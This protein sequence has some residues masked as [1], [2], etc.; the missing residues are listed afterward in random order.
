MAEIGLNT[1]ED[2]E[3]APQTQAVE[4]PPE[5]QAVDETPKNE[6][7]AQ[8]LVRDPYRK[9]EG[10]EIRR[11]F[12]YRPDILGYTQEPL[13]DIT[14]RDSEE[15]PII[16][17]D[18]LTKTQEDYLRKAKRFFTLD[19]KELAFPPDA[20]IEQ[21]YRIL[22]R[23]EG[24]YLPKM[25]EDGYE[26]LDE[27]QN[28]IYFPLTTTREYN[29]YTTKYQPENLLESA[30]EVVRQGVSTVLGPTGRGDLRSLDEKLIKLGVTNQIAR[31][32]ALRGV[33][34]GQWEEEAVLKG[35][36]DLKI[37]A[38]SIPNYA[39]KGANFFTTE[40]IGNAMMYMNLEN[41][42]NVAENKKWFSSIDEALDLAGMLGVDDTIEKMSGDIYNPEVIEEILQPRG[43]KQSM[44]YYAAPEVAM[45]T[46]WGAYKTIQAA[47]RLPGLKK[48]L[49]ETY[50]TDTIVDAVKKAKE[51]GVEPAS[52]VRGY[53]E[54]FKEKKVRDKLGKELDLAFGMLVRRPGET[55][56]EFLESEY[57]R[58]SDQITG[59]LEKLRLARKAN[60][61]GAVKTLQKNLVDL[62]RQKMQFMH[63]N[64]VPKYIKDLAVEAGATV[65]AT[66]AVTQLAMEFTDLSSGGLMAAEVGGA[67]SASGYLPKPLLALVP[68]VKRFNTKDLGYEAYRGLGGVMDTLLAVYNAKKSEGF[69]NFNF[70]IDQFAEDFKEIKLDFKARKVLKLLAQQPSQFQTELIK[71]LQQH[72]SLKT[73]LIELS[74][75]TGIE[76]DPDLM[77]SNLSIMS[78]MAE[79]IDISRQLDEKI[80]ATDL[81]SI[82]GPIVEKREVIAGQQ[83]L[84]TEL[85]VQTQALLD[86]KLSANLDDSDPIAILAD[87]M[88]G[89]V[90]KQQQRIRG[91]RDLIREVQ[92]KF[93][94]GLV[95]SERVNFLATPESMDETYELLEDVYLDEL[96]AITDGLSDD[97]RGVVLN[98]AEG[99]RTRLDDIKELKQENLEMLT[100]LSRNLSPTEAV[101]G[102]AGG[103]FANV[104]AYR[105]SLIDSDIASAY[106]TFDTKH[107]DVHANVSG[108]FDFFLGFGDDVGVADTEKMLEG[109]Q[110][111][112]GYKATPQTQKGFMTLF[113]GAAKRGIEA[114]NKRTGGKFAEGIELMGL[115]DAPPI[116]QWMEIRKALKDPQF[117]KD[118]GMDAKVAANFADNMPMLVSTKEWRA[119]NKHL[120]RM[121]RRTDRDQQQKY[122]SM[123]DDWQRVGKSTLDDGTPNTGAFMTNWMSG[124]PA[125]V[126]DEVYAE[127]RAIQEMYRQEVINRYTVDNLIRKW[128]GSITRKT[129]DAAPAPA[130]DIDTKQVIEPEEEVLQEFLQTFDQTDFQNKPH[131]WLN[132]L[133]A[134]TEKAIKARGLG[135]LGGD[136]L[137]G[138][139]YET[140]MAPLGKVAG[141]WDQKSG[142]YL[143]LGASAKEGEEIIPEVTKM[144]KV[145][146][147]RHLQ[148]ILLGTVKSTLPVDAKGRLIFD[149]KLP[150]EY[151]KELFETYFNIP[152]YQRNANGEIVPM[153]DE[154]GIP[155]KLL[156]EEEVYTSIDL[157]ALERNRLDLVDTFE[158]ANKSVESLEDDIIKQ[159]EETDEFGRAKGVNAIVEEEIKVVNE[160]QQQFLDMRPDDT[161]SY[162]TEDAF[163]ERIYDL[164]IN[165]DGA[166]DYDR[167]MAIMSERHDPKMVEH[168]M[169]KSLNDY[170]NKKTQVYVG[171]KQLLRADGTTTKIPQY[172]SS[173]SEILKMIGAPGSKQR[174]RLET[175]LGEDNVDSWELVAEVIQKI[176]PPPSGAGIDAHVSSMSL[177]SVLSRI[178][179]INRGVVSVQW[180]ATESII[181]ASRNHSGAMLR[182]MLKDKEVAKQILK[183]IETNKVPAY[184]TEPSWLRTLMT[185][186]VMQEARNESA[187][188]DPLASAFYGFTG[189]TPTSLQTYM[190]RGYSPLELE[191]GQDLPRSSRPGVVSPYPEQEARIAAEQAQTQP[192]PEPEREKTQVE[193]DFEAM[194]LSTKQFTKQD[195]TP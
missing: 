185:E 97:V 183:I 118:M 78:G 167:I 50:E 24:G 74:A 62:R 49:N 143:L 193:R 149:P 96:E 141:V 122:F 38:L 12:Q 145:A 89:F 115:S 19:R 99:L 178:Y 45:Y 120:G 8:G 79:L 102:R 51:A 161:K 18:E 3:V 139:L 35:L 175:F 29:R 128:D 138:D 65:G 82:A 146:L 130:F 23:N 155:M 42:E 86:I 109:A 52:L 163:Q 174:R 152:L 31:T 165:R 129:K 47:R 70:D 76:I 117:V 60:N 156:D 142:R 22:L 144:M 64:M 14:A 25:G 53:I 177:D 157:N 93:K 41:A 58:I 113:N 68:V 95:Q 166:E 72:Q 110:A 164:L 61:T 80:V 87:Q 27:N 170:I 123:Y 195:E 188:T 181:R 182:A 104:I 106:M 15:S 103:Q 169:R 124:T 112:R 88:R 67:L 121:I 5:V 9:G 168:V 184:K 33:A 105:R 98:T 91:D 85:A 101:V 4:M 137:S 40:I 48:Y 17:T 11:L 135:S 2:Q 132:N 191:L 43:I 37:F 173:A 162:L 92:K 34:T 20:D 55:R 134:T 28:P 147:T 153:L 127:F 16:E 6:G 75:K 140:V 100:Q 151:N 30:Q 116:Q 187:V 119:V 108:Q 39:L 189:V 13:T 63:G 160:L 77:I 154:Q 71:G 180:V 1:E 59:T 107:P 111:L 90:L 46:V 131:M 84:L 159:L 10:R 158:E 81:K 26:V 126:G 56:Q 54:T 148:G 21:K 114:M 69:L 192:Q 150:L 136:K 57:G 83:E 194:G 125:I 171:N 32:M 44:L 176:D 94:D 66:V 190:E 172:E 186:V 179:N 133:M 73:G 7:V 36:Q